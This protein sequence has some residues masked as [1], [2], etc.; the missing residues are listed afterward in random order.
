MKSKLKEATYSNKNNPGPGACIFIFQ[1]DDLPKFINE[2][3][4]YNLSILRN[5]S[6]P[7]FKQ[8]KS[9]KN[10]K[11]IQIPGPGAYEIKQNL[12]V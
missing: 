1:T 4:K 6:V 11:R 10:L 2:E 7:S 9:I 3:G 8:H 5:S 12:N